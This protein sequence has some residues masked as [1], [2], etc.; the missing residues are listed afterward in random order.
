MKK[1]LILILSLL[2]LLFAGC[3]AYELKANSDE[4]IIC[5]D[6]SDVSQDVFRVDMTYSLNGELM[7]GQGTCYPDGSA[8]KGPAVFHLDTVCFP[9]NSS[10]EGFSFNA[11]LCGDT[12]GMQELF[13]SAEIINHSNECEVITPQYGEIYNYKISGSYEEG[14]KLERVL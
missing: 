4:V 5:I 7:G 9:E 3:G 14:F 1:I 2:M 11:V 13:S 8:M 6:F 12:S 10:L